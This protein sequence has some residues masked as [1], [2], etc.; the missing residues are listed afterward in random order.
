MFNVSI[1]G[2]KLQLESKQSILSLID[3]KQKNY[4]AAKVNNRL[5]E[6]TYELSFDCD[7]QLLDLTES[8]AVKVYETSL[9]YLIAKAFN[10]VYPTYKIKISYAIS[11]S[12]L[13]SVIS[14]SVKMDSKMLQAVM[15]EMDRLVKQDL[16]LERMTMSKAD[17]YDMFVANGDTDK[18]VT[19]Q[20]RPEKV[21]HF[22][23]CGDY[24]NYMYGY[25]VPSTGYI[26]QY[27][28]FCYDGHFI[29]Q[30]PRYEMDG[31]IPEFKDEPTFS[32]VLKRAHKWAK[33]CNAEIIS[34][35][36]AH[37]Q[38]DTY[39]DFINMNETLHNDM[40][41]DL[42]N[43]IASDIENIRLICIAGPSSSG[44]TT[45]SNRLRIELM[46]RGITPL[47]ISLDMYYKN[48]CDIP[49][50]EHGD[51]DFEHIDALDVELFNK[52]ITALIDGDEVELPLYQFGEGR[53]QHGIPT[54]IDADT[55]IIIEGI[56][57]LNDKL[58]Y[59][60][61]KHQK[62]KI[63]IAPQFQLN[64]DM[65]NPISYT[66]I[67]LLRRIVRDKKY[68]S[69]SAERTLEMW[70]SVR[71]GEFKWIY[72]YQEGCNY[73]YNSALTYEMSVMKKY[74]LPA[75]REVPCDSPYYITA[76]RLIK[77]L[78]YFKD[79]DDKWVPCNSLLREFIG[80]SC[81]AEV[82]E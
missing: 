37:V 12:L 6:L 67:R 60:V 68:R 54:R 43:Q 30:Y 9:R 10:N 25:V 33:I 64:I 81:F 4:V 24:V 35:I 65:H 56:H 21:C 74:A 59:A 76:N 14:P 32:K 41:H 1:Q 11:R 52:H 22:H 20:Y 26:K 73:V 57:A 82:D 31:Q 62:Y 23:K 36:N 29:C 77:F 75:L 2:K 51:K 72:P 8:D 19:L 34:G 3:D 18:A 80:G 45:F 40:L 42:G 15:A 66:D 47:R 16:P 71:R 63:F 58:S 5:R 69:A 46:S 13:V 7:V 39:V 79:M 27:R 50:D 48:H 49:L 44:K 53:A 17:A 55:P 70:P 28:L 78:K 61:P 38:Q